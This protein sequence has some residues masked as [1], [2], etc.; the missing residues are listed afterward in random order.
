MGSTAAYASKGYFRVISREVNGHV[1][2]QTMWTAQG[3]AWA[4]QRLTKVWAAA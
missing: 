2:E 3:I 1:R 4:A